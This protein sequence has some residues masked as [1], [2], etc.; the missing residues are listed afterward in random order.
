MGN[1]ACQ[2]GTNGHTMP[3][4]R[5]EDSDRSWVAAL[6]LHRL[7]WRLLVPGRALLPEF[8]ERKSVSIEILDNDLPN[9]IGSHLRRCLDPGTATLKVGVQTIDVVDVEVDV[10]FEGGPVPLRDFVTTNLEV[11]PCA[12]PLDERVHPFR[13]VRRR[14]KD[15]IRIEAEAQDVAVVLCRTAYLPH[16]KNG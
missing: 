13:F 2:Q 11:D 4:D 8:T 12:G 9:A 6:R 3:G 7:A 15:A 14:L 16:P 10:S 1:S 5:R